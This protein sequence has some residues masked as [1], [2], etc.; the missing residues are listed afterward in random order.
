MRIETIDEPVKV[1]AD[2]SGG[3]ITPVAFRRKSWVYR[4]E[5]V[6]ARW[7]DRA[8]EDTVHYFSVD[9]GGNTYELSLRTRA[10]TWN[11]ERVV[12]DD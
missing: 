11:L 7:M 4:I 6:N 9:S 5:K 3:E 12:L 2:F 8:G 1:R 10:M